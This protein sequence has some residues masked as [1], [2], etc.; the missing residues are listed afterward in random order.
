MEM[1]LNGKWVKSKTGREAEV[2]NSFNDN[3]IDTVPLAS[4]EETKEAIE[5][6]QIGKEKM[7][8]IPIHQRR[9]M[10]VEAANL[11]RENKSELAKLLAREN[12]KPIKQTEE[13]VECAAYIYESFGEE[14][15]RIMGKTIPMD[16]QPGLEGNFAVTIKEPVGVVG[17]IIPF[18][19]PVELSAHKIAPA[20]AAGNAVIA[21]PPT[22]CPLTNLKIAELFKE[23]GIPGEAFQMITGKGSEVGEELASS[24]GVDLIT[25]TGSSSTGKK[26]GKIAGEKVKH[27]LME[28]GATDATVIFEDADLEKA[29]DSIIEGRL[30]RGNGQICC[31]V[32]RIMVHED[33]IDDFTE[34]LVKE[35]E[36]LKMGDP[37][38]EDTDVGPLIDEDAAIEVENKINED[39]EAGANLL[40]GGNREN[41]FY[42]PTILNNIKTDMNLF[43]EE[44]FGPVVPLLPF[45][46]EKEAIDLVNDS[47][48][49]LQAGVFTQDINRAIRVSHK[50]D[51]GGVMINWSGALRAA[52]V[53][54]GGQ[55]LS[56]LG[57]ESIHQTIDE[58]TE[59]KSIVIH[60]VF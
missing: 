14:A 58:M 34:L 2:K 27:V 29:V 11:I 23:A 22:S 47:K 10:L 1:Y 13:E 42:E 39:I 6:A 21:K 44:I 38:S 54:F 52:N 41:A 7:K 25:L 48:Y 57:R 43:R 3:I 4:K 24:D 19:Y 17:A 9:D 31:A 16:A 26:V 36:K 40:T 35:T 49:G 12:G 20:L 60:G 5:V 18:N 59:I 53:P 33:V 8:S 37:L 45:K 15:K 30:S 51:V 56:G 28:L 50:L 55:K 32:K 46:E